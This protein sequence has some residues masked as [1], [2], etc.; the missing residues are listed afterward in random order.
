MKFPLNIPV[1]LIC[2]LIAGV[3]FAGLLAPASEATFVLPTL[4]ASSA[5]AGPDVTVYAGEPVRLDG[6]ASTGYSRESLSDGTWSMRWTTGDGYDVENILKA[7]HVY[8][9]PGV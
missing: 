1:M 7:P 6:T 4:S 3:L 2:A 8:M 5:N 9:Q